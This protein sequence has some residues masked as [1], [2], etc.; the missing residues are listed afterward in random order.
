MYLREK[1]EWKS[2]LRKEKRGKEGSSATST[3][4]SCELH[5]MELLNT[6][7]AKRLSEL[8]LQLAKAMLKSGDEADLN[9]AMAIVKNIVKSGGG[10]EDAGK[11]ADDLEL[12]AHLDSARTILEEVDR[13]KIEVRCAREKVEHAKLEA[14][15]LEEAAR[16]TRLQQ[17]RAAR[18]QP[19][20]QTDATA[21]KP[22]HVEVSKPLENA[23]TTRERPSTSQRSPDVVDT[24]FVEKVVE[25]RRCCECAR[26]DCFTQR[27][28]RRGDL[29]HSISY[30]EPRGEDEL[31]KL[32]AEL[33]TLRQSSELKLRKLREMQERLKQEAASRQQDLL[34]IR[35]LESESRELRDR[36]Y[37]GGVV[38]APTPAAMGGAEAK[39]N[40]PAAD[41]ANEGIDLWQS[42]STA[43]A[44]QSNMH[45][46]PQY[47]SESLETLR[48]RSLEVN[49][50]QN[51]LADKCA[52]IDI[53]T[54]KVTG[55]K[56][57]L[58]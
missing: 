11:R 48:E 20:A 29:R 37:K 35:Q 12:K 18:Q 55:A 39:S 5:A 26:I 51:Q 32:Q 21:V 46:P 16:R 50:L 56:K 45:K 53:A 24:Q 27:F 25:P 17:E 40:M 44:P 10:S 49:N 22:Y 13:A 6:A 36:F 23:P 28:K 2:R 41:I 19:K 58:G 43:A 3:R 8:Q 7:Q 52:T 30:D 33:R 31:Q 4:L 57:Y 54:S 42:Q 15:K 9:K 34:R 38:V 14:H 47:D 1:D